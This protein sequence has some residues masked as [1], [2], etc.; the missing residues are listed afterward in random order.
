MQCD[1]SAG[2][3]RCLCEDCGV[4]ILC[5]TQDDTADDLLGSD[6]LALLLGMLL[7]QQFPR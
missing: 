1:F 5:L 7:D 2:V 3:Y 4:P 6:P